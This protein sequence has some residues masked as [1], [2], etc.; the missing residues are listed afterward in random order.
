MKIA[1]ALKG[2]GIFYEII[3]HYNNSTAFW[4]FLPLHFLVTTNLA[5]CPTFS[6]HDL[7]N[8]SQF[9]VM[10]LSFFFLYGEKD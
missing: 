2:S 3:T 6:S 9:R 8:F 1:K 7:P 10:G 4:E 5:G